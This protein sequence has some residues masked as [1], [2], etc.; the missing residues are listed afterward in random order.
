MLLLL[1]THVHRACS[2]PA[3]S[4][5]VLLSQIVVRAGSEAGVMT[6][7]Y[8]PEV[9]GRQTFYTAPRQSIDLFLVGFPHLAA[10]F[11]ISV[12][13]SASNVDPP[14]HGIGQDENLIN[15]P[16]PSSHLSLKLNQSRSPANPSSPCPTTP[17]FNPPLPSNQPSINRPFPT[18][19]N[20]FSQAWVLTP[21]PTAG[22]SPRFKGPKTSCHSSL[23]SPRV[24]VRGTS[25][26]DGSLPSISAMV[27]IW[28]MMWLS[29]KALPTA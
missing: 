29:S 25:D 21:P 19:P 16:S 4:C 23:A 1:R 2:V 7:Q 17:R 9:A 26:M 14:S 13:I 28:L 6:V 12:Y 24:Y 11:L 18:S 20:P 10:A 8:R 27:A 3:H 5:S 22:T 15:G